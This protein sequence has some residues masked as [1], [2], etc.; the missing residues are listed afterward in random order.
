MV[1]LC[2]CP[3][4]E[5]K[6]GLQHDRGKITYHSSGDEYDGDWVDGFMH[7]HGSYKYASGAMYVG[8][9]KKDL[10]HGRGKYQ[11]PTGGD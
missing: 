4:G 2:I 3:I 7:G 1:S 9:F 11:H 10:F 6:A 8:D 5:W